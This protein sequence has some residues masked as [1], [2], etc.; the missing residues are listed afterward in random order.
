VPA[1]VV[2]LAD[3]QRRVVAAFAERGLALGAP[4]PRELAAAVAGLARPDTRARLAAAGPAAVDGYGAFRARDG[5][6]AL[7][8]GAEPPP[9][10]RY[11]PAR[12]DDAQLLLDWRNDPATR[13]ASRSTAPVEPEQHERWLAAALADPERVLLVVEQ[14]SEPVG[15][16][17]FDL[18]A[19]ESEIS[20]TI[21]PA[22]RGQGLASQAIAEAC[23]LVLAARPALG[24]IVAEVRA[25]NEA[26]AAGFER[27]GFTAAGDAGEGMR[28]LARRR[29]ARPGG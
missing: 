21:A 29:G 15:T 8:A 23:E 11:R 16:L 7:F 4:A 2:A 13:A 28:L 1:A 5:L 10:L 19:G 12:A 26:S 22:R 25:E 18:A 14:G 6:R 3:N 27:A 20:V 24:R 17:R 9:V